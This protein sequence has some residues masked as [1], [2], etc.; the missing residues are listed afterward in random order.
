MSRPRINKYVLIRELVFNI[1]TITSILGLYVAY[2]LGADRWN[3]GLSILF[4]CV[5]VD[6]LLSRGYLWMLKHKDAKGE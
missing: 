1:G 6:N 4:F 2:L 3:L 5:I